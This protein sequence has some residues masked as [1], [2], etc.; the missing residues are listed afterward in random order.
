MTTRR[1]T[2]F[3]FLPLAL[4]ACGDRPAELAAPEPVV[5]TVA[6]TEPAVPPA[7]PA[8]LP[9]KAAAKPKPKP[10]PSKPAAKPKPARPARPG[11]EI[12]GDSRSLSTGRWT[13]RVTLAGGGVMTGDVRAEPQLRPTV[14]GMVD[15]DRDGDS[16]VFVRVGAGA[17]TATYAVFTPVEDG[18]AEVRDSR[19]EPLRL[20]VGGTATH[21]DGFRCGSRSLTVLSAVA[22]DGE[23]FRGTAVAY[24]WRDDRVTETSRSTFAGGPSDPAVRAAYRIDCGTISGG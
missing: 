9:S 7:E 18:M 4:T 22:E 20:V 14:L 8:P 12:T 6:P 15:A 5:A 11:A 2:P 24:A 21:G 16:E 13:L 17:S 3:L 1:L 19:G 23:T 10:A